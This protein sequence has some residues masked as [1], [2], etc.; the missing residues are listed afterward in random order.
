[1][2]AS[3]AAASADAATT[4]ATAG[5]ERAGERRRPVRG[6]AAP[7]PPDGFAV[8]TAIADIT[9]FELPRPPC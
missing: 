7:D 2:D 8:V 1:M 6:N 3:P 5:E 9:P 4:I